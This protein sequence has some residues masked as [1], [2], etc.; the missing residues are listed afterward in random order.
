MT[1]LKL[2]LS[3]GR[4]G[5]IGMGLLLASSTLR[6]APSISNVTTTPTSVG[7]YQKVEITFD[8]TGTTAGNFQIPYDPNPP[9]GLRSPDPAHPTWSNP[10][11]NGIS[12]YATFTA[13]DGKT[14]Q[15]PA[16]FYHY[17]DDNGGVQKAD[18]DGK[19]RDWFYPTGQTTWM[20]RFSPNQTGT[21]SYSLTARDAG[22]TG[23]SSGGSFSV[24]ASS[25]KGFLHPSK[26]DPRYFEFDDGTPL[27]S[28]G[29]E[30]DVDGANIKSAEQT[31]QALQ[32]DHINV[33]RLWISGIYGS[34]WSQ[35]LMGTWDYYLP[36]TG[37]IAFNNYGDPTTTPHITMNVQKKPDQGWF[38]PC[39]FNGWGRREAVKQD[40]TYELSITYWGS[41]I[42]GNAKGAGD[43][44]LVGKIGG[45]YPGLDWMAGCD[46]PGVGH[47]ITKPYGKTTSDWSVIKGTWTP[48]AGQNFLSR[49]GIALEN[50]S[51]TATAEAHVLDI[52][53][54]EKHGDGTYGPDILDEDSMEY[55]LYIPD[56]EA[57]ALDRIVARAEQYNILLK[58][59]FMEKDDHIYYMMND[60]GSYVMGGQQDNTK[61]F[62]GAAGNGRLVNKT[63]WLQ[64]AWERYM[65]AR[66]GYSTSIHSWELTNEGDIRTEHYQNVDELGKFMHCR[67][68]GVPV[69]SSGGDVCTLEHPNRHMVTTSFPQFPVAYNPQDGSGLFGS[70]YY[71][72][73]DY[74]D[75]HAYISTSWAS[76]AEK[77]RMEGDSA[78]FHLWH[79]DEVRSFNLPYPLPYVRGEAGM[80]P[81]GGSTDDF[82]GLGLNRD[83]SG[84]WYHN[85]VW[86]GLD[87]GALYEIYWY[88]NPHIVN[89]PAYD[90]RP[91]GIP[92]YNFL[93]GVPLNNGHYRDAAAAASSPL[94][95]VVGQKDLTNGKAHLWIQNSSHTWLNVVNGVSIPLVSGTVTIDG[96]QSLQSYSAQWWNTYTGTA[97]STQSVSA[98][99]SGQIV[100][101]VSNLAMDTAVKISPSGTPPNNTPPSPPRN[102][103]LR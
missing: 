14:F 82:N 39:Y 9:A 55:E 15:Q 26:T 92:Y 88:Y 84:V 23:S 8:I 94:L 25:K 30:I 12:V 87:S 76:T 49:I 17:Y 89:A 48:E 70:P 86:A 29:V 58:L 61:G 56:Q 64:Q 54:R 74:G 81:A 72:N 97:S 102:L 67:V 31:F 75:L 1:V 51:D 41:G 96:F 52:S 65:Q 6:A 20:V 90:H 37:L 100:L 34:A 83:T 62:Y 35:Y 85:Y 80:V 40:T 5:F 42:T 71:R 45:F 19:M 93:T 27:I 2:W 91:E 59:V 38:S 68:F 99:S 43:Y 103:R 53:L 33:A 21:W 57:Y 77:T 98:N 16:F 79:S 4:L 18:F 13:P 7:K 50:I 46:S 22:G 78:F 10:K 101:T 69:G 32:Q 11:Y 24:T 66:W 28:P 95:R 36:R 73:V 60:D 47:A 63:R 44:G 3:R